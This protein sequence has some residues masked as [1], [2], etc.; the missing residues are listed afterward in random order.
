MRRPAVPAICSDIQQL[1]SGIQEIDCAHFKY[2][3]LVIPWHAKEGEVLS[4][5]DQEFIVDSD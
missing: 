1:L 4:S 5:G 3:L 2:Q